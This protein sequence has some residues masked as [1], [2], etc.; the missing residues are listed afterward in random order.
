MLEIPQWFPIIFRIKTNSS[1][2]HTI[3]GLLSTV[4]CKV[5]NIKLRTVL[6]H[7]KCS[8]N[9]SY[10][11]TSLLTSS[12]SLLYDKSFHDLSLASLFSISHLLLLICYIHIGHLPDTSTHQAFS[13]FRTLPQIVPFLSSR[14]F[15]LMFS[16]KIVPSQKIWDIQRIRKCGPYTMGWGGQWVEE[17][18]RNTHEEAQILDF[19]DKDFKAV[20]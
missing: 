7:S 2:W 20:I 9:L 5:I 10:L 14:E 4:L 15:L 17:I 16:A 8:V 11:S 18:I 19:L 6:A 1:T 3:A 12:S 13:H